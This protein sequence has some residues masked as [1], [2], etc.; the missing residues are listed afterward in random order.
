MASRNASTVVRHPDNLL[1]NGGLPHAVAAKLHKDGIRFATRLAATNGH[2]FLLCGRRCPHE[3]GKDMLR[4]A[5]G[6]RQA[7]PQL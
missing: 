4:D 7:A 6:I 3:A 2:A 5:L 1:S